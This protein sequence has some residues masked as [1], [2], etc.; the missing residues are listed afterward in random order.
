M[1]SSSNLVVLCAGDASLHRINRW[2]LWQEREFEL[3]IVY[4]GAA[5]EPACAH[6]G[7]KFIRAR[8]AKWELIREVVAPL[9]EARGEETP[10]IGRVWLPDDDLAID[11]VSVNEFFGACDA[12][13]ADI[14]Q[15]SLAP[16]NAS[17]AELVH[18]PSGPAHRAAGF[19]EI[20]MPCFSALLFQRAVGLLREN[21]SNRSG[22]GMDCVWSSWA[23]VSKV[24]INGVTAVHT[25]PVDVGGGFYA[26][27]GIDPVAEHA[28]ALAK[29]DVNIVV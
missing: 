17:C 10:G 6:D 2:H 5:A 20:Q 9:V 15:P 4:Y 21:P 27:L 16:R 22:W 25:K 29:Y 24:V 23:G 19:I 14:A 18:R 3:W 28:A 7:D 1:T 12:A 26:A 11:V 13:A 8:G